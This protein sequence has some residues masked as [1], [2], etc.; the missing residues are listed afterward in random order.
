[1]KLTDLPQDVLD[2]LCR[3]QEWRL[4]IDPGFDSKHEFWMAWHHFLK[5]PE[6]S[7]CE[8]TEED[9]AE[10]LTV[11]GYNLLLPVERSHHASIDPIRL[12][13]SADG[14]TLTLF[15]Q[16]S[17]HCDWFTDPSD[18]RYGFL[19]ICDRYQKFGCDFYIANYYHFSY[20]IGRDYEA[21]VA[22]LTQKLDRLV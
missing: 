1:M 20:L 14:Q 4:D 3:D 13:P 18:A 22:M 19:A 2:D 12:I 10:F 9:L 6:Q 8:S 7:Y 17:Y 21:A 11:E 15:L 5:L 16:D